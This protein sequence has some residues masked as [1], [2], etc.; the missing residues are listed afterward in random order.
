MRLDYK[1]K[2]EIARV[3]IATIMLLTSMYGLSN[4]SEGW[5]WFLFVGVVLYPS[6]IN[7]DF[8]ESK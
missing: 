7:I 8:R 3:V 5:G 2:F 4:H 1:E 6:H